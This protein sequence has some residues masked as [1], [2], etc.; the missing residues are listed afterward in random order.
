[1]RNGALSGGRL[2]LA[3]GL[4]WRRETPSGQVGEDNSRILVAVGLL[5]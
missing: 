2:S 1:M 3:E 4:A 5:Y